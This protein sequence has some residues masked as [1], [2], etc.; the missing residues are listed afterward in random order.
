MKVR[1]DDV[2]RSRAMALCALLTIAVIFGGGGRSA[3]FANLIVQLLALGC[4]AFA[5]PDPFRF[6]RFAPKVLVGLV[7]ATLALPLLHA[8]PIPPSVWTGLPGRELV[9]ESLQLIGDP[10]AWMSFSADQKLSLLAFVGLAPPFAILLLAWDLPRNKLPLISG[11]LIGVTG[12]ALCIGAIQLASAGQ[13]LDF[14][15]GGSAQRFAGFFANHNSAGLYFGIILCLLIGSSRE[16]LPAIFAAT[17]ARLALGCVLT[18]AVL[19]TQSRSSMALLLFPFILLVFKLWLNRQALQKKHVLMALGASALLAVVFATAILSSGR[20]EQSFARFESLDGMRPEIW[21]DGIVSAERFWPL[22]S[23]MGTFDEV[24]QLDEALESV[25]PLR[26]GRAHNDYLEITIEAGI[27]GLT[28]VAVWFCYLSRR[29]FSSLRHAKFS[30]L[31]LASALGMTMIAA[32][33]IVDYPL[34]NGTLLCI[35]ALLVV[36]LHDGDRERL[37]GVIGD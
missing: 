36:F 6:F 32:Q 9:V 29:G 25:T 31:P 5:A 8:I 19:L 15:I 20:V 16:D 11:M 35:A 22:G 23:G 10:G 14:Y 27:V 4:L 34:R 13:A 1:T 28:L 18:I 33:S 7:L 26:A 17:P 24:F 12:F 30:L 2:D 3:P 37:E 21:A